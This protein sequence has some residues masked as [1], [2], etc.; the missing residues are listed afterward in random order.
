MN[1]KLEQNEEIL[2][3]AR[4][5]WFIPFSQIAVLFLLFLAPLIL[6]AISTLLNIP[7]QILF[8]GGKVFLLTTFMG[9]WMLLLWMAGFIIWTNYFLDLLILTDK[10]VIEVEQKSLFS[11]EIS[12]FG[13]NRIQDVTIEIHG[14]IATFLDFGDVHIHTAGSGHKEFILK[15][16]RHP[17][18]VKTRILEQQEIIKNNHK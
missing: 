11:R 3:K 10:K 9:V 7:V 6:Y 8:E 15:D 5:H 4:R 17:A 16:A 12:S 14:V 13:L 2:L 1:I 18:N